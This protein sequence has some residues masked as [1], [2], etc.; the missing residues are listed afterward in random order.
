MERDARDMR[1]V[2]DPKFDVRGS[3]F[4]QPRTLTRPAFLA[5]LHSF[6]AAC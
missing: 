4:R 5:R 6:S 3:K 2:R 1:E